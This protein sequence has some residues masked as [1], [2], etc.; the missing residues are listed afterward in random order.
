MSKDCK[1]CEYFDGYDHSDGTP[2]CDCDGGYE[3]CPYNNETGT[4]EK[5]TEN[6]IK[7]EIDCGFMSDFIRETIVNTSTSIATK[8][9]N[10]EI[11]KIVTETYK[12][13]IQEITKRAIEGTVE[14]QVSDFMSG[15]IT[16]GGGWMEP[17]RTLT[18]TEYM[19]ELVQNELGKRFDE[20][21]IKKSA[22]RE[23]ENAIN[24][25]SKKL[26]DEI[27][28]GIKQYFDAAT[29]SVLTENVVSMLMNNDTYKRL[30]DSMQTFLPTGE[31]E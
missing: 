2:Y 21:S 10:A 24:V 14:K 23:A 7:V 6:G 22:K 13:E 18:R 20:D 12:S 25:F 9:A 26:K 1:D 28:M 4:I 29:R 3:C 15:S 11:S 5:K 16:V 30:S 27:N 19:S 31:S 17:E 8:L